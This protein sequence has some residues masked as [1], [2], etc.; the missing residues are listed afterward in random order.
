MA[1]R[2]HLDPKDG[3][4]ING[5]GKHSVKSRTAEVTMAAAEAGATPTRDHDAFGPMTAGSETER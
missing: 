5:P 4:M 3:A 2:A 1:G